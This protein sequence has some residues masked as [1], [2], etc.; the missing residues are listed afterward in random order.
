M[1]TCKLK[2][3]GWTDVINSAVILFSQHDTKVYD[4]AEFAAGAQKALEQGEVGG[5]CVTLG[6]LLKNNTHYMGVDNIECR[7]ELIR[8]GSLEINGR[9]FRVRSID[10]TRFTARVHWAPSFVPASAIAEAMGEKC[11]VNSIDY[12][13]FHVK[14]L[15]NV[16]PGIRLVTMVGDRHAVPHLITVTNYQ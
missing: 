13:M 3:A 6:P 16:S 14:G 4:Y 1:V 11:I 10:D 8:R 5:K 12:K 9:R 7:E 15:E 2:E